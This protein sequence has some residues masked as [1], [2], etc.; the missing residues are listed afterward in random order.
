MEL[1]QKVLKIAVI[2]HGLYWGISGHGRA[3]RR[4]VG[5]VGGGAIGKAGIAYII[6][7][8][9]REMQGRKHFFVQEMRDISQIMMVLSPRDQ[10]QRV[11][12]GGTCG[13]IRHEN[14]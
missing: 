7:N 14:T 5:P 9:E 6:L 13:K 11:E 1:Q 10:V 2:Q 4:P 12:N 8:A 3:S